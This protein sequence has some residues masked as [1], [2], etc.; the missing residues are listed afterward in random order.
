PVRAGI[1]AG[2]RQ[3]RPPAKRP[4]RPR[5]GSL[6]ALGPPRA[7][8][9][10]SLVDRSLGEATPTE[11]AHA[12]AGT[13]LERHGVLTREAVRGEGISGGFA[14]VYTVLRAMEEAGRIRRGYFV[15]GLREGPFALPGAVDRL[16][17][18]GDGWSS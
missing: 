4:G 18:V 16:R 17:S 14:G 15:A 9:R 1:G 6:T 3:R 5:V 11:A 13:L 10:W 2:A 7:Q 8:G 12:L